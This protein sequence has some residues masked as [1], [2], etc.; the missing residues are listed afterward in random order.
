VEPVAYAVDDCSG[1]DDPLGMVG[2]RLELEARVVT[3]RRA[4]VAKVVEVCTLAGVEV[5]R[6]AWKRVAGVGK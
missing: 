1:I 5:G 4:A 6:V 2:H 3:A